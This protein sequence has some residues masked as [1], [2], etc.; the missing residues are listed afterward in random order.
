MRIPKSNIPLLTDIAGASDGS[1]GGGG[2]PCDGV[3]CRFHGVCHVVDNSARCI[4]RGRCDDDDDDDQGLGAVCG[5]DGLTYRSACRLRLLA[6]RRQS[7]VQVAYYEP[8]LGTT[9][10]SRI[11]DSFTVS[12]INCR[13]RISHRRHIGLKSTSGTGPVA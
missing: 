10:I 8:C 2:A 5:T 4:C 1:A 6:C 7:H 3:E 9:V 12:S 13:K 11:H